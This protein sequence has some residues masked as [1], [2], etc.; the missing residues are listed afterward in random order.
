MIQVT[1][2]S[3]K[4]YPRTGVEHI[5][6]SLNQGESLAILGDVSS[7]R[8]SLLEL[9]CGVLAPDEGTITIGGHSLTKE[10]LKAKRLLGY[11]PQNAPFYSSMTV[12]EQL[13]FLHELK[14]SS[15]PRTKHLNELCQRMG[16][17]EQKH[18]MIFTLSLLEKKK[19][20]FL[21]AMVGYP[22]LI[23]L[24]C[25]AAGLNGSEL[26][27][28][29]EY[30]RPFHKQHSFIFTSGSPLL[31]ELMTQRV[32]LLDKGKALADTTF[33]QL[34][35]L[36]HPDVR[37]VHLRVRGSLEESEK[38]LSSIPN[39][40]WYTKKPQEKGAVDFLVIGSS[41]SIREE[42]FQGMAEAQLPLL[43][44]S[45]EDHTLQQVLQRIHSLQNQELPL[46]ATPVDLSDPEK[47]IDRYL[48][49]YHQKEGPP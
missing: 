39:I 13:D 34:D 26:A 22:P 9:L 36:L 28:F 46:L 24:D 48:E 31:S 33:R 16:L 42:L 43:L 8:T 17:E 45:G 4:L 47:E 19:L 6:F 7:G 29:L 12:W 5:S 41:S 32:L 37:Q 10:P 23:L 18:E 14:K 25:P 49:N 40:E 38:V 44:L 2:V 20:A 3:K 30:L 27:D 21:C 1:N 11:M 15:L 35:E